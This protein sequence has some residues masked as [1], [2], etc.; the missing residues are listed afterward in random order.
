MDVGVAVSFSHLSWPPERV[1]GWLEDYRQRA[2]A[3]GL[4]VPEDARLW[5]RT[6]DL[7]GV[8]RHL[9]VLGIFARIRYRDGKPH[10]LADAP[11][12]FAYLKAAIERNPEL[13]LLDRLLGA[14]RSRA[15]PG[16]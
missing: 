11:R 14:W 9:K 3:A 6:C 7:M 4:P 10:Y 2:N 5:Q 16:D 13:G 1:D 15:T 12:F 8:Q